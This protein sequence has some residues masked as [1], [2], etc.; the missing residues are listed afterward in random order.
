M[1]RKRMFVYIAFI[2]MMALLTFSGCVSQPDVKTPA[3]IAE[4]EAAERAKVE[5]EKRI[6]AEEEVR[7]K[8]AE[9]QRQKQ[10]EEQQRIIAREEAAKREKSRR[11][12]EEMEARERFVETDI[13]FDY[14]ES[15]LRWDSQEELKIKAEWM[16]THPDAEIIIE[17]HCDERGSAAY[18]IALGERRAETAKNFIVDLGVEVERIETVSFGEERPLDPRSSEEAW[19]KNRRSHFLIK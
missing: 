13:Y 19:S 5:A 7:I 9:A 15:T 4:Q 3:E 18:N 12:Q 17:G 2:G 6:K 16:R 14:N 1:T 10:I 8:K 11:N